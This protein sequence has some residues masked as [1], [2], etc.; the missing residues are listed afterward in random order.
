MMAKILAVEDDE[1]F[2]YLLGERLQDGG[3]QVLY[4]RDG[5]E[6]IQ[7]VSDHRPNLVLLDVMMPRM[8]GW[9]ACRRIREISDVPIIMLSCMKSE[10]DKVRGLELGADDYITKPISHMEFMAR[11][12]AALRR[13]NHS[14]IS[15]EIVEVDGRLS[16]DRARGEVLV[17]DQAVELSPIEFKLLNC[18]LDNAGR[19]LTHASLLTQVWGWEYADETD[20]LKVYVH[21]LRKK[22][23]QDPKRPHYIITERGLG[24]RFEMPGIF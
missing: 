4:A 18:F 24:Y 10:L 15:K 8:D 23:E 5:V 19:I 7:M 16:V 2:S 20:Y 3:Y 1:Q 21:S 14:P 13:G 11:I 12:R 9:E 6:A 17:D 22:I